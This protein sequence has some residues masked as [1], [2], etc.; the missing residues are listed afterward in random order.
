LGA[1]LLNVTTGVDCGVSTN[2]DPVPPSHP[3][4]A[5]GALRHRL[6]WTITLRQPVLTVCV[7]CLY[8]PIL[9]L[10]S[11]RG[12]FGVRRICS[13]TD[14]SS[15]SRVH[16]L[17]RSDRQPSVL[18]SWARTWPVC[19]RATWVFV[20]APCATWSVTCSLSATCVDLFLRG[21]V[22]CR[23]TV[24]LSESVI[25]RRTSLIRL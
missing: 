4:R 14:F 18:R 11:P 24:P 2:F 9:T 23:A 21:C 7:S 10:L 16:C 8:R 25:T 6:M 19:H 12:F 17:Y 15:S 22:V 13:P 20:I 3:R 5:C 1:I